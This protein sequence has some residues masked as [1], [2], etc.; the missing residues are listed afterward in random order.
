[1]RRSFPFFLAGDGGPA[2]ELYFRIL[3][4]LTPDLEGMQRMERY[5]NEAVQAVCQYCKELSKASGRKVDPVPACC[6]MSAAAGFE[7]E[8]AALRKQLKRGGLL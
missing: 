1:M 3:A 6:R 5:L 8:P 7:I 4:Q 2:T